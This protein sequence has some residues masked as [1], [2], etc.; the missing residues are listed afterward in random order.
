MKAFLVGQILDGN[1]GS[2]LMNGVLLEHEGRIVGLGSRGAVS[3]PEPAQ[4]IE[5]P[6]ATLL[7]GLM[8][9]HVHLAYSGTPTVGAFRAE[10]S[11]Q[12]YPL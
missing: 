10:A 9:S 6:Q 4:V 5:A 11:E 3:I 2:P 12:S 8:D 1:G 7:P